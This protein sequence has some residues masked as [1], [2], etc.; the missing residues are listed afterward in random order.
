MTSLLPRCSRFRIRPQNAGPAGVAPP[1]Q[2]GIRAHAGFLQAP[3][4]MGCAPAAQLPPRHGEAV[5]QA[6]LSWSSQRESCSFV[7]CSQNFGGVRAKLAKDAKVRTGTDVD[8][9]LTNSPSV[10]APHAALF[11]AFASSAPFARHPSSLQ[12]QRGFAQSSQR[13]QRS[14]R[15]RTLTAL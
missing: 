11:S 9:S 8:G 5:L 3:I 4:R 7:V 13:T 1:R 10:C 2:R 6:D 14:G 12:G 15:G